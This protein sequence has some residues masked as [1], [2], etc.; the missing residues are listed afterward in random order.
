[1]DSEKEIFKIRIKELRGSLTQKQFAYQLGIKHT[2]ISDYETGR[3]KPTEE[4]LKK[5][6]ENGKI[7][8]TWL[9]T[10]KGEKYISDLSYDII[11]DKNNINYLERI[12]ILENENI[13]LKKKIKKYNKIIN[14]IKRNF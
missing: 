5:F 8:L 11:S 13:D 10:G 3:T 14:Y 7:N 1:M 6:I 2:L 4:I 9:L 12:K